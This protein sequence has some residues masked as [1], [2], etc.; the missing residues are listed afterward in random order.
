MAKVT[1]EFAENKYNQYLRQIEA[2][3]GNKETDNEQLH[4]W[5]KSILGNK[6][7]GVYASDQIPRLRNNEMIIVNLDK[8]NEK[9]SHW[10]GIAK[11]ARFNILYDSF[12]RKTFKIIPSL[13]QSGNGVTLETENDKEQRELESN[14]GQR[15]LAA[16]KVFK[17][18]GVYALKHI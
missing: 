8:S 4:K 6:F 2:K 9:G 7:K 10:V 16:L 12:G 11:H 17:N 15:S 5:G 14:C 1:K 13:V 18:Y 3:Y